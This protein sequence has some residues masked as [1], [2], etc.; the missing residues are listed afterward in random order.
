MRVFY[1]FLKYI[2]TPIAR[3]MRI[4]LS[5]S[6]IVIAMV[7]LVVAIFISANNSKEI[8]EKEIILQN[9]SK[10]SFVY[11]EFHQ[12]VERIDKAMTAFFFD[13]NIVFYNNKL[14]EGD[15]LRAT[16]LSFFKNKVK[17]SLLANYQDFVKVSYYS[18]EGM[19]AFHSS[20]E[21]DITTEQVDSDFFETDPL[22]HMENELF[23]LKSDESTQIVDGPYMTKPYLRFVDQERIGFLIIRLNLKTLQNGAELLLTEKDA[24]VQFLDR[25]AQVLYS[26]RTADTS[27]KIKEYV[28]EKVSLQERTITDSLQVQGYF[29]EEGRYVFYQKLN[30]NL[31]LMKTIPDDVATSV[32]KKTLSSQILI[33]LATSVVLLLTTFFIGKFMTLPIKNL[34]RSMHDIDLTSNTIRIPEPFVKSRDEIKSLEQSYLFMLEKINQLIVSEY[35]Q[36]LAIQEAQFLA[37]QAQI[38]PHFMYNTLQMIGAMAI[39]KDSPEIYEIIAAFS[40]ML[41]YTMQLSNDFVTL[42]AETKNIQDYLK[43][44]QMR[45]GDKLR[46]DVRIPNELKREFVPK[47]MLQPLVENAFKYAFVSSERIWEI[48]ILAYEKD[49][50]LYIHVKDSGVGINQEKLSTIQESLKGSLEALYGIKENIG[51]ANIH[52]RIR[53]R[54]GI[55]YGLTIRSAVGEGTEITIRLKKHI[56]VENSGIVRSDEPC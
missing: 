7:P 8:M 3:S 2:R 45:F 21:A 18:Y 13:S 17:S 55:G 37:L 4:K 15:S 28:V 16:A 34:A 44:Q 25:K 5:L 36:K 48:Q 12:N 50:D 51:L 49:M 43:I 42:D 30:D 6:I 22:F 41:R 47:L 32:Y 52:A 19:M 40:N 56:D 29:V 53:I 23:Y 26:P 11:E 14:N 20:L 54:D 1:F 24:N 33:L 35:N 39:D 9:T 31:I 10:M 38:N 46:I 27:Q